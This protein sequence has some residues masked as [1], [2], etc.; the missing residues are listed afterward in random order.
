MIHEL[1]K[2][3]LHS[4]NDSNNDSDSESSEEPDSG[5]DEEEEDVL[6]LTT[7]G[8][9]KKVNEVYGDVDEDRIVLCRS[10]RKKSRIGY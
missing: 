3:L 5:G 6:E 8:E 10:S 9:L 4:S 2:E 1:T 7:G